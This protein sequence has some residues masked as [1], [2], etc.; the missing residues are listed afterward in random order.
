MRKALGWFIVPLSLSFA[1]TAFAL[2]GQLVT[3]TFSGIADGNVAGTAFTGQSYTFT[4]TGDSATV[5]NTS[6]PFAN[7]LT[8]GS[9]R[10]SGTACASGCTITIPGDYVV[11]N[12]SDTALVH[13]L[14]LIGDTDGTGATFI[15]GCFAAECGGQPV[16]DNLVRTVVPT[17][18]GAEGA[19]APYPAFTTSGGSVQIARLDGHIT[20]AVSGVAPASVPTLANWALMLLAGLL[21]LSAAIVLTRRRT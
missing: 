6:P 5:Q 15:E 12:T 3:Y 4:L 21:S 19:F 1:T 17:A 11:F 10:I 8:G 9:I 14:S 18:S 13:G 2:G 16:Y 7:V 20:Y